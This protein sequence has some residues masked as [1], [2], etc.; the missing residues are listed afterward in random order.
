MKRAPTRRLQLASDGSSAAA[1]P[2]AFPAATP[3][4]PKPRSHKRDRC[5]R[6][7]AALLP[8]R[9]V[10]SSLPRCSSRCRPSRR[11]LRCRPSRRP[12]RRSAARR[13]VAVT[14][15]VRACGRASSESGLE[16]RPGWGP[17]GAA[18]E[19]ASRGWR[20]R[21][22]ACTTRTCPASL[23]ATREAV[24]GHSRGPP[25]PVGVVSRGV[26]C[27]WC[28]AGSHAVRAPRPQHARMGPPACGKPPPSATR[29]AVSEAPT[30][31]VAA[32]G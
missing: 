18:R 22:G 11:S 30:A 26:R 1:L 5:R 20:C 29:A 32:L 8:P 24:R 19:A 10:L 7:A 15:A 31:A 4:S 28:P 14:R 2:P 12:S 23:C 21:W 9:L 16:R 3:R 13:L 17:F 6:T 27:R 25:H